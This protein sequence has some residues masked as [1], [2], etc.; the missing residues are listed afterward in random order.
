MKELN[1]VSSSCIQIETQW[2]MRPGLRTAVYKSSTAHSRLVLSDS[3]D[4]AVELEKLEISG[5]ALVQASKVKCTCTLSWVWFASKR[6]GKTGHVFNPN[7]KHK[8]CIMNVHLLTA[9][10]ETPIKCNYPLSIISVT[11]TVA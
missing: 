10:L 11:L 1:V 5:S 3:N 2:G 9:L 4:V 8:A 6:S 7:Q